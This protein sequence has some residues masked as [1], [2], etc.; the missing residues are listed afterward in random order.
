ML[1]TAILALLLHGRFALQSPDPGTTIWEE[2]PPVQKLPKKYYPMIRFGCWDITR[3]NRSSTYMFLTPTMVQQG[4]FRIEGNHYMFQA[5]MASELENADKAKL[6][7]NMSPEEAQK[8]QKSYVKA[9]YN[10]EGYYDN[11][12][13]CLTIS[14]PVEGMLQSFRLYD[15]TA[16]DNQRGALAGADSGFVGLWHSPDPHPGRLDARTRDKVQEQGLQHFIGEAME[17][18][19]NHFNVLDLRSDLTYRQH[20]DEG[21][22][23]RNGSTLSIF[24]PGKKPVTFQISRDGRKLILGG[25]AAYVRS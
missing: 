24:P 3:F 13:G 12:T 8:F 17:S 1:P 10:F 16:G 21:G 9:M 25:R 18:D 14:Y 11:S 19:G 7:S 22:W 23:K 15:T 6:Q 5:V 20:G 2:E 4:T